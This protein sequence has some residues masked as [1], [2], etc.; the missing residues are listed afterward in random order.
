M[1]TNYFWD[2]C[3]IVA[4]IFGLLNGIS[5]LKLKSTVSNQNSYGLLGFLLGK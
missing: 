2:F 4:I 3:C 1:E 5:K